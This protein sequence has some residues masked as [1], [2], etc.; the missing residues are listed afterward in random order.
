LPKASPVEENSTRDIIFK[1]RLEFDDFYGLCILAHMKKMLHTLRVADIR[2]ETPDCVSVAF[3][4]PSYLEPVFEYE[5]GQYITLETEIDGEAVRRSY[6]LCSSPLDKEWRVAIK[7]VPHGKFS[8]F[9]NETLQIGDAIQALP[10]D[11]EFTTAIDA[12][13]N[14]QYMAFA[15]GSG[16]TPILSL[17]KTILATETESE[18]TL[19]YGNRN[20]GSIIFKEELEGLKNRYMDR[21]KIYHVL[22]RQPS[23]SPLFDGRIDKEKCEQI[24]PLLVEHESPDEVFLCGPGQMIFDVRDLLQEKGMKK[25]QIRFELFSSPDDG[26]KKGKGREETASDPADWSQIELKLDGKTHEFALDPKGE[27]ILNAG[28]AHGADLP[29]SCKGGVCSTCKAR[30]IEGEVEMDV[31]YALV[32]EEVERGFILSCQAHPKSKKV[33]VDFDQS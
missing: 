18:F 11:G 13:R 3:Q 26:K 28:I 30:V 21:F 1:V 19:F 24:Y 2:Q 5:P 29:F 14:R 7:K 16:I 33:V 10:P 27:N 9:A 32:D 22:S 8:T 4:I 6:S 31:N 17:I 25:E 12:E 23:D 15:A 20:A